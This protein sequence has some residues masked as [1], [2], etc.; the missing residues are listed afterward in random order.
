MVDAVSAA[1]PGAPELLRDMNR[2]RSLAIL[3]AMRAVAETDGPASA[4]DRVALASADRYLF[5]QSLPTVFDTLAPVEPEALAAA[6]GDRDLREEALRF[7]AVMAFVPGR[8]DTARID[9]VLRY[10]AALGVGERYLDEIRDAAHERLQ[11]ALA[12]MIRCNMESVTGRAWSGDVNAWLLPYAG[13]GA[14]PDLAQRFEAL[15]DLPEATF[16]HAFWRHFKSNRY[17]FPGDPRG[18]NAAFIVPHDSTHVLTRY[19]T[20]PRGEILVSTFTA[21]M[22]RK[23]PMAGHVLPVIFSWHLGTQMNDVAGSAAGALDPSEFWHAWAAGRAARVDTF[24]PD[25]DF[26]AYADAPLATLRRR[27]AIPEQGLEEPHDPALPDAAAAE[28]GG[29]APASGPA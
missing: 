6:L 11:S 25:W 22:H 5:G 7:L 28:H 29:A 4:A 12:D 1:G 8:L 19:H 18:V 16:G 26:W 20:D 2:S 13:T 3:G 17:A 21:A 24:A 14:D 23:Y 10:A 15:R 27:W 9:H